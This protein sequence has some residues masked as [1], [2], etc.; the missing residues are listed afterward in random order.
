VEGGAL[1]PFC[2]AEDPA[3]V[4]DDEVDMTELRPSLSVFVTLFCLWCVERVGVNF[5][6]GLFMISQVGA[7]T[8][9]AEFES[10][11]SFPLYQLFQFC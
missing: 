10:C 1:R 6:G 11:H 2:V 5:F 3:D 4:P 8:S 7:T 9:R